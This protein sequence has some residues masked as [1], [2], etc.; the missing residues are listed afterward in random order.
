MVETTLPNAGGQYYTSVERFNVSRM[1]DF[2]S[3]FNFYFRLVDIAAVTISTIISQT[4]NYFKLVSPIRE[5]QSS[6]I[7][8]D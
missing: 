7:T 6:V 8:V 2:Q 1:R 4:W 5:P 3:I